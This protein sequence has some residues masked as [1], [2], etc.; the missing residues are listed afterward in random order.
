MARRR[1][2]ASQLRSKL[3]QLENK[4]R[5]AV[6]RYN[7]AVRNYNS[8]LRT[9]VNQYNQAARAHNA[10][11]RANRQRLKSELAKL[12]RQTTTTRYTTFRVSV[13]SVHDAYVRYDARFGDTPDDPRHT[14]LLDL[15][16]R[17]SAN[18]VAVMNALLDEGGEGQGDGDEL[19]GTTI[20]TE[21]SCVS[22]DLEARWRGAVFALSPQNPDAARHFC[23]SARE[24]FAQMLDLR[25][26]NNEVLQA[27]PSCEKTQQ[28]H[29][30]RRAKIHHVLARKGMAVA[31]LEEFVQRDVENVL[32][33]FGVFNTAT[34]G[35]A[36]RYDMRKL[37][38]IKTRVE[39]GIQFLSSVV[40]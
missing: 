29:P 8:K 39:E 5:Q 26:P 23:T 33:L 2:N 20:T 16:E 31:E 11:V 13:E 7:Q 28:G 34:H 21:L 38:V 9:A 1:I 37:S 3:R 17:E 19:R 14:E 6:N 40:A 25:A 18:S 35:P 24:V 30:T 32:E 4:Q 22:P 12:A 36:G 15:A 27:T 10:R